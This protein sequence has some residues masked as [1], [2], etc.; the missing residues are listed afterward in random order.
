[1]IFRQ[2]FDRETST[3]TY[4]LADADTKEAVLID[5]VQEQVD[6]DLR[7]LGEL[8]LRLLYVLDTHVH[9]DH[10]TAAGVLRARTSCK[11]GLSKVS[12]VECADLQLAEPDTLTLGRIVIHVLETPGHTN[13]CLS[14]RVGD[15]VFTGDTL[16]IRGCGRTDFQNGNAPKLYDSVTQKLFTLPESTLVFPGHDYRGMTS[17]TIGEEK[18]FNP[19][20]TKTRDDFIQFMRDL[21]LDHPKKIMEAVPAN[22]ECGLRGNTAGGSGS[23]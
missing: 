3:Y 9:A 2:L 18:H 23:L 13:G 4:L 14:Y 12:G 8:D 7:L 22:L 21:K 19:R 11:T 15:R 10:I 16:L 6:R 17:S 1:M 5:P 20:L